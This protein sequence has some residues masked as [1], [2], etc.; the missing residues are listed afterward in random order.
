MLGQRP[1]S[2]HLVG[3]KK[4]QTGIAEVKMRTHG[5][6]STYSRFTRVNVQC[7]YYRRLQNK[8]T[9]SPAFE[10]EPHSRGEA[11]GY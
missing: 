9:R 7:A 3:P 2:L 1:Y 10:A 8:N 4:L 5:T 11:R 6:I